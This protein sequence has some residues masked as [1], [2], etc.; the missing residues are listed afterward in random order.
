MISK[1][2]MIPLERWMVLIGVDNIM[3]EYTE[4]ETYIYQSILERII[5]Y[6]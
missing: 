2:E 1:V 3:L 4:C 5:I 6:L